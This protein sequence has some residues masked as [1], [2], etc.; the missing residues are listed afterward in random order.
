M[1]QN[2]EKLAD[3]QASLVGSPATF[4]V[5]GVSCRGAKSLSHRLSDYRKTKALKCEA[6]LVV[7]GSVSNWSGFNG[8]AAPSELADET[9][10][11]EPVAMRLARTSFPDPPLN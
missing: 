4:M 2:T 5:V 6:E 3:M 8:L 1:N 9:D 11:N 10:W 7:V